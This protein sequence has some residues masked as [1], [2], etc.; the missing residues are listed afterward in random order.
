M[1]EVFAEHAPGLP[2][3]PVPDY[4]ASRTGKRIL[5]V[6]AEDW[7]FKRHRLAT[8]DALRSAGHLL[9]VATRMDRHAG[10]FLAGFE[11]HH[12]PWQRGSLSPVTMTRMAAALRPVLDRRA[13]DVVHAHGLQTSLVTAMALI[14]RREPL[15]STIT[16]LGFAFSAGGG[17]AALARLGARQ[18][19]SRLL[20]R[21]ASA[22]IAQNMD[23][24][25]W[26]AQLGVPSSRLH[27]V[28]GSGI[29]VTRYV[30]SAPS[31]QPI[32]SAYAGRLLRSKGIDVLVEA[33]AALARQG[34]S[35]RLLIAGE[36][37][38]RSRDRIPSGTLRRWATHDN[39]RLLGALDDVRPLWEQAHIAV[40]ASRREG[41][42]MSLLE[43]AACGRP[44]V[45][46]DAP[47]TREIARH[48]VNALVVPAGNATQLAEAI[49]TLASD[50][51]LRARL[52]AAGREL[53]VN[54]FAAPRVAAQL[55]TIYEE[56]IGAQ[57]G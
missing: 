1:V 40:F 45:A 17:A 39:V 27:L 53:V 46:T 11:A 41:L 32:T 54:E 7:D 31:E 4:R 24:M 15:V 5:Y 57:G 51:D 56:Q 3:E 20:A 47:G 28:R 21:R 10:K 34:R 55:S 38:E 25:A 16:G 26:L 33:H 19:V 37:D 14:G 42:P 36:P 29:D 35:V 43:A 6:V 23:D 8:A 49:A 2:V 48:G 30:P 13:W 52:G 22:V 50:A 18:L 9:D 12:V 44:I